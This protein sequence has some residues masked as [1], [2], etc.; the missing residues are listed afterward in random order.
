MTVNEIRSSGYWIIGCSQAVSSYIYKCVTCRKLRGRN[1]DQKMANLP[2]DRLESAPFSYCGMDCFGPFTVKDGRKEH[3]KYGLLLTCMSCRAVHVEMLDDMST[4]AL[5]NGLRCFIA[6]R[7][8]IRQIRCDQGSNFIG[9]DRILREALKEIQHEDVKKFLARNHCDFVMNS[10]A[11]SHMGGV[12]ERMIRTV[13]S[14]LNTLLNQHS[15][16][17]DSASL[18]TFLYEA[19]A[20]VNSRPLNVDCLCDPNGPVPITP[21]HLLTMKSNVILPP[22]GNFESA[23]VY[24]KKHWRQVQ[25]LANQFWL[26]WKKE[27]MLQLQDRQKWTLQKRNL[28]VGDIV[29][30]KNEDLFRGD[31]K[32]GKVIEAT[33]DSDGLV[34]KVKV[35]MADSMLSKEGKR[36]HKPTVLERPIHK[37]VLLLERSNSG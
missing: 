24:S 14:V 36:L 18:R 32:L 23:D 11:S 35:L 34:R 2:S 16:R 4:D 37:L 26:R 3:K 6:F 21:N 9:A 1:Q 29:I 33:E 31:W 17:L 30:L 13:R 12:W 8:P 15:A 7:G 5:I 27:Y 10:P 28:E 20:I 22:P 19:M 25:Y